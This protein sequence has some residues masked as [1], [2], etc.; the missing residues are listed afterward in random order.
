MGVL[1]VG[2]VGAVVVPVPVR[3]VHSPD[4]VHLEA[5]Q[6]LSRLPSARVSRVV[7]DAAP[8]DH[9][10]LRPAGSV[11]G[12]VD[13]VPLCVDPVVP[14]ED[15][16]QVP[17]GFV[18]RDAEVARLHASHRG[19]GG[20]VPEGPRVH[21]L[22]VLLVVG[23]EVQ[24]PSS[25]LSHPYSTGPVAFVGRSTG[26]VGG[27]RRAIVPRVGDA[28]SVVVCQEPV[29]I[30]IGG[31][32]R[33]PSHVTCGRESRGGGVPVLGLPRGAPAEGLRAKHGSAGHPVPRADAIHRAS[34]PVGCHHAPRSGE[35][36]GPRGSAA[37]AS[38]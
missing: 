1:Q 14:V 24:A 25:I 2:P 32:R 37:L 18:P 29:A 38:E 26:G 6:G 7:R 21:E 15:Q 10:R 22:I 5:V 4:G 28:P 13:E 34:R 9:L 30:R 16:V 31:E 23:E 17:G 12:G 8:V 20:D 35:V 27:P 33:A 36:H 3:D 19:G 11:E